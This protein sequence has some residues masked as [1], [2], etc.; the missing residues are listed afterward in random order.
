M[1]RGETKHSVS[2]LI[3]TM[4][5]ASRPRSSAPMLPWVE[6]GDVPFGMLEELAVE[7]S[8]D[9]RGGDEDD[10]ALDE[11]EHGVLLHA[12]DRPC[13]VHEIRI[14]GPDVPPDFVSDGGDHGQRSRRDGMDRRRIVANHS[15]RRSLARLHVRELLAV[16]T[17]APCRR[18]TPHIGRT[19]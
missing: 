4:A 5:G 1:W 13:Q 3:P 16:L 17:S 18:V 15:A 11:G 6:V 10:G 7:H 9:V 8:A 2:W 14:S 12:R 19:Q